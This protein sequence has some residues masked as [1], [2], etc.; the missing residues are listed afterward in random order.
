MPEDK[1]G[2]RIE[3][4]VLVTRQVFACFRRYSKEISEIEEIRQ[5]AMGK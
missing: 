5:R 3:D 1:L 4:D 2:V